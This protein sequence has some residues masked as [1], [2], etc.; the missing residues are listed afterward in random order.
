MVK[1]LI[2]KPNLHVDLVIRLGSFWIGVHYS[3]RFQSYCVAL[4]PC[5]V[6]RIGKTPYVMDCKVN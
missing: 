5:V 3:D 2:A 4:F 6:V 1:T